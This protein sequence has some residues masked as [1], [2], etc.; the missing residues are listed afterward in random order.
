MSNLHA[1]SRSVAALLLTGA[2]A[3]VALLSARFMGQRAIFGV[4]NLWARHALWL[5][6]VRVV[7][8]D[9]RSDEE[10]LVAPVVFVT[11]HQSGLD[12][13]VLFAA[14]GGALRFLVKKELRRTPL[15]GRVM[16]VAGYPFVDRRDREQAH[17]AIR[18]AA[19]Q[20]HG[21]ASVI[22]F[23]EGTRGPEG[24]LGQFKAGAF[25]SRPGRKHPGGPD[26]HRGHRGAHERSHALGH[27]RRGRPAH[28]PPHRL[29]RP[30]GG[31]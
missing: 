19:R 10:R 1:R 12:I 28:R 20:I 3:S 17:A 13:L 5:V 27:A 16:H 29:H 9:E 4:Q 30:P 18:D 25:A 2:Y 21:R 8:E 22:V 6:G 26:R 23:P 7:V 15:L 24:Q 31:S 11:N 14:L